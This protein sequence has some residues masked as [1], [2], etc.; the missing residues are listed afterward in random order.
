MYHH[1]SY[2]VSSQFELFIHKASSEKFTNLVCF[3][4][5]SESSLNI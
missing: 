5:K 1:S 2:Y 4:L 3:Y